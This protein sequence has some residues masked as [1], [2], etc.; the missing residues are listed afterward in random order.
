MKWFVWQDGRRL[1]P[2]TDAEVQALVESGDVTPQHAIRREGSATWTPLGLVPE[3]ARGDNPAACPERSRREAGS[4]EERFD[5]QRRGDIPRKD[6]SHDA[7]RS[8]V[9]RHWRGDLSLPVS[10]W[11]NGA[12]ISALLGAL[13]LAL[14]FVVDFSSAPRFWSAAM[15]AL[16]LFALVAITWQV[17]GVWRSAGEHVSRGGSKLWA[18]AARAAI[19]LGSVQVGTLVVTQAGPQVWELAVMLTDRDPTHGYQIR[20]L[21]DASELEI[22]GYIAF[23]LTERVRTELDAHPGVR[24]VHLNSSGGRVAEARKLRDLIAPRRLSTCTSRQCTS[25][26]VIPFLAGERRLIAPGAV[27]GFHQYTVAGRASRQTLLDMEKDKRYFTSRGVSPAFVARAFQPT[28]VL[29]RPTSEQMLAAGFITGYADGDET[30]LSGMSSNEIDR[31]DQTLREDPMYAVLAEFEPAAYEEIAAAVKDSF[32]RGQSAADLRARTLPA[33]ERVYR[34][35]LPF[36]SDEAAVS[37]ARLMFDKLTILQA[38]P[39][40]CLAFL[41]PGTS[42]SATSAFFSTQ[43]QKREQEVMTAVIQS[44]ASGTWR[45]PDES[46]VQPIRAEV[47]AQLVATFTPDDLEELAHLDRPGVDAARACEVSSGFYKVI[48]SLPLEKAGPVLRDTFSRAAGQ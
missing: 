36:T 20:L 24:V 48:L 2:L 19:I 9:R 11:L 33:I 16:W 17:V 41:S 27:V 15:I 18:L 35:R 34:T 43:M 6:G 8:Y 3:L 13:G 44:A 14:P 10:Y 38:D 26:C 32:R 45:P 42:R 4:H 39:G 40:S 21:R 46:E 22:S 30:A 1:G 28:S 23:G 12:V 47:T 7:Q 25:A 29:W 5:T 31:L 37:F